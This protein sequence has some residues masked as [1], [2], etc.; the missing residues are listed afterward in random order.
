MN[1]SESQRG[2]LILLQRSR[3]AAVAQVCR[4]RP[5]LPL[6]AGTSWSAIKREFGCDSRFAAAQRGGSAEQR[7]AGL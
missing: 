7:V 6:D 1:P 4:A 3:T 5:I 2:E